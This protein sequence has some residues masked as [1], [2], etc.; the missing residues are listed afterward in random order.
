MHAIFL[1]DLLPHFLEI[2]PFLFPFP[3]LPIPISQFNQIQK[4]Q[5]LMLVVLWYV[6]YFYPKYLR[7]STLDSCKY[8][9]IRKL[10]M[11]LFVYYIVLVCDT[12]NQP[13]W[14]VL[15]AVWTRSTNFLPSYLKIWVPFALLYGILNKSI[16]P[17]NFHLCVWYTV[18]WIIPRLSNLW[19]RLLHTVIPVAVHYV[20]HI[21]YQNRK[22]LWRYLLFCLLCHASNVIQLLQLLLSQILDPFLQVFE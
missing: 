7:T 17:W 15:Y 8:F 1:L 11:M 20:I 2:L 10:W 19:K 12:T 6:Q 13:P 14:G 5:N 22:R 18:M 3:P 9:P 4:S 16:L 21:P